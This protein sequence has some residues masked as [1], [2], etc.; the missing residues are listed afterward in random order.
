MVTKPAK[1]AG[2]DPISTDLKKVLRQ[3]KLS[4]ILDTLPDRLALA[5]QQHLSHAAFLELV[6]AAPERPVRGQRHLALLEPPVVL[7][8]PSDRLHRGPLAVR[9]DLDR[10]GGAGQRPGRVLTWS[11]HEAGTLQHVNAQLAFLEGLGLRDA[12]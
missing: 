1:D 2:S 3:L 11:G 7:Q 12:G 6:L 8:Q 4:P 9:E 10:P 5:R